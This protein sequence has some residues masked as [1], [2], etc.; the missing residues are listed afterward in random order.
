MK[1]RTNVE[2]VEDCESQL[3]NEEES[4]HVRDRQSQNEMHMVG[5]I[6]FVVFCNT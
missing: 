3:S 1:R 4:S 5:Y 6:S 2:S